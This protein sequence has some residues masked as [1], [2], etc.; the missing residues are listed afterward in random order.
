MINRDKSRFGVAILL[1]LAL[2]CAVRADT[3]DDEYVGIYNLIQQGDA[4]NENGQLAAAMAKYSHAQDDLK[5]SA[6]NPGLN[7]A[8]NWPVRYLAAK[9]AVISMESVPGGVAQR[10]SDNAPAA[11]TAAMRKRER[12]TASGP[13]FAPPVDH[14]ADFIRALQEQLRQADA[15]RALLQAKLKEALSAQ[16]AAV[17]PQTFYQA[18]T[19]ILVLE[20]E[21]DLLKV[22]LAQGKGGG[23]RANAPAPQEVQ[24]ELAEARQQALTAQANAVLT[25]E[26]GKL[27]AQVVLDSLRRTRTPR[28]CGYVLAL[29]KKQV[30]ELKQPGSSGG[31]LERK[32]MEAQ[33]Q[34]AAL[35]SDKEI[36]RLERIALENRVK[37][38]SAAAPASTSTAQ[39]DNESAEKISQLEAERHA[40]QLRL[41]AAMSRISTVRAK[42]GSG[43]A[44]GRSRTA[45]GCVAGAH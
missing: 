16:P 14:S 5:R 29:L 37:Q 15:D 6:A 18:Q 25:K 3:G 9:I 11:Q 4:L 27:Q 38:M 35:Q 28:R 22:S 21:N 20:K 40:L 31:D 19:Q 10:A 44:V 33:T 24:R 34:I 2:P 39:S 32:L 8:G 41:D 36:L 1:L 12:P 43:R 26:N 7:V 17:D 30:A 42:G 13:T 45:I 23:S